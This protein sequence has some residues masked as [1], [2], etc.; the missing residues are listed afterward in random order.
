MRGTVISNFVVI[1]FNSDV[2]YS[3]NE[4]FM[5]FKSASLILAKAHLTVSWVSFF[6]WSVIDLQSE[7]NLNISLSS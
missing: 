2:I 1:L 5:Y 4:I 6:N 7:Q 3:I